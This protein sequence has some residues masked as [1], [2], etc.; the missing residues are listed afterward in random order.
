MPWKRVLVSWLGIPSAT[1]PVGTG[2]IQIFA[3]PDN[4]TVYVATFGNNG[5]GNTDLSMIDSATCNATDLAACPDTQPPTV[6]VG[7]APEAIDVDLAN[8]TVYVTTFGVL[9]GWS[10]FDASSCNATTESGCGDVGYLPR[11]PVGPFSA[12]VDTANDTLYTAN[13]DNTVSAFELADCNAS[14]LSGCAS[15]TP[16]TVT[17]FPWVGFDHSLWL[18]VDTANHSVYVAYQKDDALLVIDADKCNGTDPAGCATLTP[19]RSTPDQTRNRSFWT[20]RPRRSTPPTRSTT[21]SR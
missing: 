10:V 5:S 17:P 3:D 16:G 13:D 2:P 4:H 18:T 21:P 12:E 7:A 20:R 6:N 1:V 19:R 11:D 9:N 14:D 15:D 8:H